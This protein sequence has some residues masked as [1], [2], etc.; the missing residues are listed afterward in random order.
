MGTSY[1]VI[2]N[3]RDRLRWLDKRRSGLGASDASAILGLNPFKSAMEVYAEKSG[4]YGTDNDDVAP[5]EQARWGKIFESHL[6]DDFRENTGR[7]VVR[8]GRLLRSR[9]HPWQLCT[10]DARQRRPGV[11]SLGLLEAKSTRFEWQE[12]PDDV[13]AQVQHQFSVTGWTW[14]NVIVLDL[15]RRNTRVVDVEPD[16]DFIGEMVERESKFWNDL[17]DGIPPKPDASESAAQA[18]K[19]IY[20]KPIEGKVIKLDAKYLDVTD[21]FELVKEEIGD[22]IKRRRALENEIKAAIGDAEAGVLPNGVMYTHKLQ[23]RAEFVT[24]ASSFRQL[25]RKEARNGV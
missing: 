10:L 8:D 4:L 14:G 20:R 12:L 18:L 21:D 23:N 6:L 13:N 17:V 16:R 24:K 9:R 15:M 5:S 25:R 22:R 11:H 3:G 2:D 19:R 7:P 1:E